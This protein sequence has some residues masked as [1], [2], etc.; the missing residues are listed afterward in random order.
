MNRTPGSGRLRLA[1]VLTILAALAA[2]LVFAAAAAAAHQPLLRQG[3]TGQ[4]V[5][6]LQWLLSGGKPSAYTGVRTLPRDAVDG[7]FGPQTAE[8]VVEMKRRLGFPD[9]AL[10]PVAGR[11]LFS[12][13]E[14]KTA[15]PL[16]YVS[17][18]TRRLAED[19][20]IQAA[21]ASTACARHLIGVERSQLGVH[22]IPDGSNWGSHIPDYLAAAGI[23]FPA[24][25]CAA[26]QAWAYRLARV[27]FPSAWDGYI[28]A[29]KTDQAGVFAIVRNA[30]AR[31][32]IRAIPKP[33][34][35]AAFIDRLGH[36]E[37][38]EQVT[39]QGFDS[40]GGNV[41]NAVRENYHPFGG[42]PT[43]FIAIPGCATT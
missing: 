43:V 28:A 12:I 16:G 24:P 42:R 5:A 13:L 31:G 26:F 40:I 14:G 3:A 30:Q 22:E 7:V 19:E 27:G 36:V 37:L 1:A 41:S 18:A 32:W 29:T 20:Q 17:R 23:G 25:W 4:R 39:T 15:R 6:G 9:R 8:A 34:M 38:V 35:L 2:A 21:K 10:Q 11:D 33:G